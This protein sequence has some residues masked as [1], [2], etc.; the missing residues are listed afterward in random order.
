MPRRA[1]SFD[2][3]H[4]GEDAGVLACLSASSA[5]CR[6]AGADGGVISLADRA[7]FKLQLSGNEKN[8]KSL[9][10]DLNGGSDP[11]KADLA[12][13][14]RKRQL[15]TYTSLQ[16]IEEA[17]NDSRSTEGPRGEVI[18]GRFVQNDPNSLQNISGK[19]GLIG[20]L[21]QKGLG[22]RISRPARRLRHALGQAKDHDRPDRGTVELCRQLHELV[23]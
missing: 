6:D 12:A 9:I 16:K 23:G 22:T 3:G 10:E 19:L 1:G 21:I 4:V 7:S 8:R 2:S 5:S 13:F 17:L 11:A 20:R 18:N 14:V 15:Q